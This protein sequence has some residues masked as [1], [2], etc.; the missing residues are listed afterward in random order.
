MNIIFL[1]IDGVLINQESLHKNNS[2][3]PVC[4]TNINELAR[5]TNSK[6]VISSTW[7]GRPDLL[8]VLSKWGCNFSII[9]QTPR[10]EGVTSTGGILT[11]VER[12]VEIKAW[13]DANK[14]IVDAFI[15]LDDGNDMAELRGALIQTDFVTGLTAQNVQD[16]IALFDFQKALSGYSK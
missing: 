11:T 13:L 12:G 4:V 3:D 8:N 6:I 16:G 5:R 14:S 7:R 2:A 1:D 10:I 15:I 9:G